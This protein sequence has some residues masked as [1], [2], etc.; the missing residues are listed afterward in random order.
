MDEAIGETGNC[1]V[2][3][4]RRYP[5]RIASEDIIFAFQITQRTGRESFVKHASLDRSRSTAETILEVEGSAE[6]G[7][8]VLHRH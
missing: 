4:F 2:R 8:R 6:I 3:N 7:Y 5:R 1:A